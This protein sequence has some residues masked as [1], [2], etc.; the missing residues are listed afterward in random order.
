M[1]RV[2]QLLKRNQSAIAESLG[3]RTGEGTLTPEPVVS[4]EK[5]A[6]RRKAKNAALIEIDKIE[7]EPQVRETF[8]KD[9]LKRLAHSLKTRGQLQ[10]ISVRWDES[11]KKYLI[12]AG[13]RRYRAA[14]LAKLRELRC[15]VYDGEV[16]GETVLE[17]QLVENCLREDLNPVEQAR[18]Y[19]T[20][21]EKKGCTGKDLAEE[22]GLHPTTVTRTLGLLKLPDDIQGEVA[23]GKVPQGVAREAVKLKDEKKQRKLLKDFFDKGL[24]SEEAATAVSK[25]K[26]GRSRPATAKAKRS[27]T[28]AGGFT[29]T[30][31]AVKRQSNRAMAGALRKA[32]DQ[33]EQER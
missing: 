23:K 27:L 9:E 32:A 4:Q 25:R 29:V 12:I 26:P 13:E 15:E 24:T 6:G 19:R 31:T 1:G 21:M 30:I 5:Y 14:K 22:L 3:V 17:L 18:A 2:E 7:A 11:R 10:P 8:D 16:T 28:V 33:L 20:L